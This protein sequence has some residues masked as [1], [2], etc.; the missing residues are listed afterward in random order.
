LARESAD[1]EAILSIPPDLI[2]DTDAAMLG[3]AVGNLIRNAAVH[4]GPRAKVEIHAV[5]TNDRVCIV[6]SDNGPGVPQDELPRIFEP[7]Y[8]IDRS[9][10]RDTG[11]SGLGLAIVR[12][13]IEACGGEAVASLPE[14]GGFT[15]TLN[16]PTRLTMKNGDRLDTLPA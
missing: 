6:V 3:R 4:A 5:E 7:F 13:A 11:G 15:V 14:N 10:S 16:L 1:V 2:I 12:T 9:R 8:R